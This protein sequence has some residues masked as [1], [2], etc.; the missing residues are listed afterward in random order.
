MFN[1]KFL[2]RLQVSSMILATLVVFDPGLA[3]AADKPSLSWVQ[4]HPTNSPSPRSHFAMA[5]DPVSKK[6]VLFGG[7]DATNLYGDTWTFD[8]QN[9]TQVRTPTAPPPRVA[10]MLAYDVPTKKLV[11]FGGIGQLTILADTWL[12]DGAT[13]AWTQA[14]PK[15]SPEPLADTMLFTDPKDG[16]AELFGGF[17]G[18]I[19]SDAT[20]KWTGGDW[21]ELH[22][23]AAPSARDSAIVGNDLL[24]N[25]V[26]VSD[27]LGSLDPISTWTWDGNNWTE[28]SPSNALPDFSHAG[29]AYDPALHVVLVF[30]GMVG[31]GPMN[32]TVGW[33]GSNWLRAP[34][35]QAPPPRMFLGMT[36]DWT[37]RETIVF[38]GQGRTDLLNDTWKLT[39]D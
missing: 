11:M 2:D 8:G 15:L 9:W 20:W 5:Y 24:K 37:N 39:G 33:T 13:L 18:T 10:A 36:Y 14:T 38:G 28:Q 3:H 17:N 25:N 32:V 16:H 27:G 19:D 31:N 23:A 30:G 7:A 4:V 6:T 34:T 22:P 1:R 29:A 26:V 35:L 21:I 12:W